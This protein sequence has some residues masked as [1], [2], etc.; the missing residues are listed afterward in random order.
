MHFLYC[1]D[2]S[3]IFIPLQIIF[4]CSVSELWLVSLF[5]SSMSQFLTKPHTLSYISELYFHSI[6]SHSLISSGFEPYS[7]HTYIMSSIVHIT[8]IHCDQTFKHHHTV[9]LSKI[10]GIGSLY[11]KYLCEH[12]D[13]PSLKVRGQNILLHDNTLWCPWSH[14]LLKLKLKNSS[15]LHR[16][17]TWMPL[18]WTGTRLSPHI[19]AWP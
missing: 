16:A 19:S 4:T 5:I 1:L 8:L 17:L 7:F 2:L 15:G 9:F 6:M 3:L 18:G 13:F 14:G 11:R 10:V 12:Y